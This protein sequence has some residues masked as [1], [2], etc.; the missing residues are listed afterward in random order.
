VTVSN[1]R[2]DDTGRFVDHTSGASAADLIRLMMAL[3]PEDAMQ[4][5]V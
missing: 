4:P 2:R 3:A 1:P 5:M